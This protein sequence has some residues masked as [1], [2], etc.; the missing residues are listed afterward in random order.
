MSFVRGAYEEPTSIAGSAFG[1][2]RQQPSH[3]VTQGLMRR[4][5]KVPQLN[6][7]A[8]DCAHKGGPIGGPI[9]GYGSGE[10]SEQTSLSSAAAF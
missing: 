5:T 4:S 9:S 6:P 2:P 7:A 1:L 3:L 8:M 10:A